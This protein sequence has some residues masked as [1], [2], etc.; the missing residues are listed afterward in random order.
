MESFVMLKRSEETIELIKHPH[1]FTLLT[2]IALRA[3]RTDTF[4]VHNLKVGEALIGDYKNYGLT[5]QQYRTSLKSLINWGILTIKSTN[6]GTIATLVTKSIYDINKKPA[7]QQLTIKQPTSNQ[8]ATT[9]NNVKKDKKEF[10]QD[11]DEYRLANLLVNYLLQRNPKYKIPNM[12]TW[13]EHIDKMIR[14][15]KRTV[16]MIEKIIRWSQNDEFWHKNI[17]STS[18]LR[19]KF[20]DLVF[21]SGVIPNI[22]I[23]DYQKSPCTIRND[24]LR[25]EAAAREAQS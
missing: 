15:D 19:E 6:K 16:A 23:D 22:P 10:S 3:R 24:K 14:I 25:A 1:A 9:N 20:D 8:Q 11:S 17:L 7:N 21:K 5:R 12:Q 13:S 18:K 2:A 4:N